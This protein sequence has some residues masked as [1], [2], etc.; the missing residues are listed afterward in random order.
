[1]PNSFSPGTVIRSAEVNENFQAAED[2]INALETRAGVRTLLVSPVGPTEEDNCDELRS[3][4]DS[5]SDA[6]FT[7]YYLIKVEP[8]IYD[9]A[10]TPLVMKPYV[11]I[12][13]SG[14]RITKIV[15]SISSPDAGAAH[16]VQAA[17]NSELRFLKVDNSA[18]SFD[19]FV[20][21][22]GGVSAFNFRLLHVHARAGGAGR[23]GRGVYLSQ[24]NSNY[25]THVT[26]FGDQ[27]GIYLADPRRGALTY[28]K[29]DSSHL[30]GSAGASA[31]G[32]GLTVAGDGATRVEV[33]NSV[34]SAWAGSEG[35]P[36]QAR[37]DLISTQLNGY[38]T[39]VGAG[40]FRCVG[41][42]DGNLAELGPDCL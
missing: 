27:A 19:D 14:E 28:V 35:V 25:F 13:G 29:V 1:M 39:V 41:A 32:K 8:G 42:Y 33:R 38:T 5:I 15:G 24:P 6:S 3:A 30:Q 11:D 12:E 21:A 36:A 37:I 4:L 16:L 18:G 9:C 23:F 22:I 2:A 20:V 10:D 17:A 26:A 31:E 34:L 40:T 7:N